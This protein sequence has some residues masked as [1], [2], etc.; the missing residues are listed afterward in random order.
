MKTSKILFQTL[1]EAPK[2]ETCNTLINSELIYSLV[3]A[4]NRV[5]VYH[6]SKPENQ[7]KYL[8]WLAEELGIVRQEQWYALDWKSV[9]NHKGIGINAVH[10]YL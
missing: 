8:D 6:W 5:P 2:P 4:R 3:Y 7:R 9:V 10:I 1:T